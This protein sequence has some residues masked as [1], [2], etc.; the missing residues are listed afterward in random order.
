MFCTRIYTIKLVDGPLN[1]KFVNSDS[2]VNDICIH[3]KFIMDKSMFSPE[4]LVTY[5]RISIK[6]AVYVAE[7]QG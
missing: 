3:T 2:P 7:I 4:N 6:E 1:G 5:K